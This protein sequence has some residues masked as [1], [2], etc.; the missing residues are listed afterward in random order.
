M[1]RTLTFALVTAGAAL[2]ALPQNP[3]ARKPPEAQ[4]PA[5]QDAKGARSD[6]KSD[7]ALL[8]T[9]VLVGSNNAAE[10]A[11]LASERATDP[12]VKKLA[13][14]VMADHRKIAEELQSFAPPAGRAGGGAK[15][16]EASSG[17][18]AGALD[19]VGL[20]RELG[21]E[22]LK[23]TRK[24]LEAKQG[25]EFDRCYVGMVIGSHL[26]AVDLL[27]VLER[28][29]SS[30]LKGALASAEQAVAGHLE[31]A[32]TLAHELEGKAAKTR[33]PGGK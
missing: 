31:H 33:E 26:G 11:Q 28:H 16:E 3:P 29:A 5:A 14:S 20:L 25:A 21:D 32:R 18:G 27:T 22:C 17:R 24:E 19:H 9:W 13:Q 15:A 4:R 30:S 8:A 12:D 23:S 10:I 7:D 2:A 1:L 6:E